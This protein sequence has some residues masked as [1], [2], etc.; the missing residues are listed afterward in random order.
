[1]SLTVCD[2]P[3]P[4]TIRTSAKSKR[5]SIRISAHKGIEL[6]LPKKTHPQRAIEFLNFKKEWVLKHHHL[7][8]ARQTDPLILPEKINL[9]AIGEIWQVKYNQRITASF[10]SSD[11]TQTLLIKT[12]ETETALAS[13]KKWLKQKALVHLDNLTRECSQLYDFDYAHLKVRLQTSRWGSCT[14]DKTIN[15]NCK[16]L[17]LPYELTYYII[18]HELV[19]TIHFNH[20][21]H[22]WAAVEKIIPNQRELRARLKI[23]EPTLPNWL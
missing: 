4:Y 5:I 19:H 2:W 7:L 6:I 20:S 17:L 21:P 16:L 13:I 9:Q 22:F 14:R 23:I 10:V 18:I 8:E 12:N 1:M 15:L 11:S 3:P